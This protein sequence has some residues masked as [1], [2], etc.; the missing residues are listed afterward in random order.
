MTENTTTAPHTPTILA[1]DD[2][3]ENLNLLVGLLRTHYQ[4]KVAN[5]AERAFKI[6]HSG[7]LPD[8][9]LLDVMMPGIDGY[10][11][12]RRLKADPALAEIP[13]IFLTAL[14]ES[15]DETHGLEIGAVD[16]ITKPL[17]PAILLARVA[18]HL[19]VKRMQDQL[20]DQNHLLEAEVRRRTAQ[21]V[22][23]QDAT[24]HALASLAETRDLETG[25]HI[26]RTQHYV[27][28]LADR[29]R[30]HPRFADY[31]RADDTIELLFKCAP[32]HD[33]GKVG[34]PDH[35]LLKPGKYEPSEFAIMKRHPTLGRDAIEHAER[36]LNVELPFLR[37]AKEIVY[38]HHEKW[39][40]SGYP[41]GLAGDAI[42]IPGR[43]MAL[44]DVYDALISRRVYKKGMPH[45]A[46]A[47]IIFEGAGRHFDPDVVETFRELQP[48]FQ[49]VARIYAD[50]EEEIHD[51]IV[52]IRKLHC[53]SARLL[54]LKAKR[55]HEDF[56]K[57]V[58][59]QRGKGAAALRSD[60]LPDHHHCA[61]GQWYDSEGR[62]SFGELSAYRKIEPV[63][64]HVHALARQI[65][66]AVSESREEDVNVLATQLRGAT[67]MLLHHIR[68]LDP[69]PMASA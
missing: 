60:D 8:L 35:I 19:G 27:R 23:A 7:I 4:V 2:S 63:H 33:I 5:S 13:V 69:A 44:A 32:L 20:R 49:D 50:S 1:V 22:A 68:E 24:I 3:P 28:L 57:L 53:E 65:L 45:E 26:R 43:L 10:E 41:Q 55:E 25:N 15:S 52:Q 14:S 42:P 48:D 21:A 61:F 62:M 34:I 38:S 16:Y 46:A 64:A 17:S 12:C 31:L 39:D 37:I 51:K 59:D 47:A 54:L 56:I 11:A 9:I 36:D 40:G 18:T 30:N 6:L 66:D 67:N 29:L 58:L